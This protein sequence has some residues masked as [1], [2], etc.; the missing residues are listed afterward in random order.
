MTKNTLLPSISPARL[1]ELLQEQG[2]RVTM[3]EQGGLIQLLTATQGIGFSARMGNAAVE[4][5]QYIDY[6]LSCALRVQT[7]LPAGLVDTWNSSKR[8]ARLAVQGS[9]LV[10]EMDV[11]LAGGV[12]EN[13]LRATIELWDRLLQELV[14]FLRNYAQ[15]Q[16]QPQAQP[17]DATAE[18]A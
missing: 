10:L 6:T 14:L 1:Q 3:S 18:T 13:H 5:G 2:Y 15:A 11:I 12:G 8:F 9:F 4:T 17:A 16:Q 7:E